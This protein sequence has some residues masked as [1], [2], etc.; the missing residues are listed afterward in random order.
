[1]VKKRSKKRAS[2]FAAVFDPFRSAVRR[3]FAFLVE[4]H[5]FEGPYETVISYECSVNFRKN[6]R[7]AVTVF[8][9]AGA[10]P[11]VE[12]HG[13]RKRW[14][15]PRTAAAALDFVIER[16]RGR[17][18]ALPDAEFPV[19]HHAVEDVLRQYAGALRDCAADFLQGDPAAVFEV[20]PSVDEAFARERA[21][22]R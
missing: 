17:T 19:P 12:L 22:D 10:L 4:E 6:G 1:M 16:R 2:S 14:L 18:I 21:R 13:R 20:Q 11:W 9:E 7:V 3:E 15:L 8:C 5:G